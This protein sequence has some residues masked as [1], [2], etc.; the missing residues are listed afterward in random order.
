MDTDAE[1]IQKIKQQNCS[2]SL[3]VLIKRHTPLV[4][5]IF[6]KYSAFFMSNM[7]RRN[8][9]VKD[10]DLL[11]YKSALSFDETKG[12]KF[13]TWLGNHARYECLNSLNDRSRVMAT[14][15]AILN[16]QAALAEENNKD[17]EDDI[18]FVFTVLGK[19]KDARIKE[20][21]HLRYFGGNKKLSWS[22]IGSKL[23]ISTQTAINLHNKGCDFL[24]KKLKSEE[25]FDEI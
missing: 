12:A 8:D 18:D 14:E 11:I 25:C 23:K 6:A 1:L 19:L 2:D 5:S 7:E 20:V 24:K 13:A 15:D 22:D 4:L 16:Y 17:P 3:Q 21:F 9:L 10:K